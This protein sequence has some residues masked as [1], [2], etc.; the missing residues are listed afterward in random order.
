[1]QQTYPWAEEEAPGTIIL[2]AMTQTIITFTIIGII[3]GVLSSR[4]LTAPLSRL[5]DAAQAIGER[6]LSRR[7]VVRGSQEIKDVARAFN[8]M[9][10]QLE[11]AETLRQSMLADI[12][13]ELR[14][15]LS[16]IQGNLQAILDDVYELDKSEIAHLYDQTRQLSR[17]VD[18]LRE[19]AQ[20]EA[21]QLPMDITTLDFKVLLKDV[22]HFYTPII[23]S[24]EIT[25]HTQI[26]DGIPLIQGDRRRLVQCIQNLLNNSIRFT[27]EGGTISLI[28][29]GTSKGLL[30]KIV[31]SGTGIHPDHLQ[32]I[33][34]RFY[35]TD[36]ARTR[37]TG[38]RGLGLA[39]TRAIIEAHGGGIQAHSDGNGK[40]TTFTIRLPASKPS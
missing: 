33:F 6:D 9:A 38:G 32:Y 19:L 18:D 37:E 8:K 36:P 35:R 40:G 24:A 5:A 16:V 14:T 17:L 12:A 30:L 1:M 4:G 11:E 34:D 28:L 25:L 26:G 27:P 31:D 15:P 39:I 29:T 10:A 2:R 20:A 23:E 7:V 3:A 21:N 22:T 13:H